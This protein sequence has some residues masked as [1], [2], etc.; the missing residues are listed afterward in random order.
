MRTTLGTALSASS[1][2]VSITNTSAVIS[3]VT[4]AAVT[5]SAI[6]ATSSAAATAAHAADVRVQRNPCGQ[7]QQQKRH[8]H[9]CR[10]VLHASAPCYAAASIPTY[11]TS[12]TRSASWTVATNRT[13]IESL[14]LPG[15][16]VW[17]R[18]VV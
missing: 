10:P 13:G 1:A 15:W 4:A 2:V 5:A 6:T 11:S 12:S 17:W 8:H 3:A 16:H 9:V 7:W 18:R 14:P